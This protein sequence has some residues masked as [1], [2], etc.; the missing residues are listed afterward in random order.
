MDH[1]ARAVLLDHTGLPERPEW[2]A[3]QHLP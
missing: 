2:A 1:Q 3:A